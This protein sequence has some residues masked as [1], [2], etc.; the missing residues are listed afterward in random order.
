MNILI[1]GCSSA[2]AKLAGELCREGHDVSV[3]DPYE[4]A[5]S[6]LPD[7]IPAILRPDC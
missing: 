3:V 7:D 5:Q 6:L 2:G 1:A 4:S